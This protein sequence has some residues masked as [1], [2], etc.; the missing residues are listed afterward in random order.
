MC[1]VNLVF[2]INSSPKHPRLVRPVYLARVYT[3]HVQFSSVA[4]GLWSGEELVR[5]TRVL[6]CTMDKVMF[7]KECSLDI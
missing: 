6:N 4:R 5:Q 3:V 1:E 2:T 7:I